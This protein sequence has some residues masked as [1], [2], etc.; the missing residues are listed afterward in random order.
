[1]KSSS[2]ATVIAYS[3]S[4]GDE[5]NTHLI[6]HDSRRVRDLPNFAGGNGIDGPAL[7]WAIKNYRKQSAPVLWI[8]DGGVTGI[9]DTSNRELRHQCY[10]IAKALRRDYR[11]Q[12]RHRAKRLRSTQNRQTTT[13]T[14]HSSHQITNTE[15]RNTMNHDEPQLAQIAT[16]LATLAAIAIASELL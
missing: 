5:P 2:G 4:G 8:T 7:L 6:A 1:M 15:K 13:A 14:P 11:A 12:C 3:S 9:G 10:K 16:V